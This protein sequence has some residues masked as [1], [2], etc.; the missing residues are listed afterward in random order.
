MKS[1]S[2]L[3]L[4]LRDKFCFF[5]SLQGTDRSP[6]NGSIRQRKSWHQSIRNNGQRTSESESKTDVLPRLCGICSGS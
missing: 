1:R 3:R 6:Q 5:S 4:N 2:S